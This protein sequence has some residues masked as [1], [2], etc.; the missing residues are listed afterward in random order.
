MILIAFLT[1]GTLAAA[2]ADLDGVWYS[3]ALGQIENL[4]LTPEGEARHAGYD[5]LRDDAAMQCIPS[6]FTR[7]MNTPSPPIEI[8]QHDNYVEINYEY[9]DIR[10]RVPLDPALT[11][12]D[13]PVTVTQHPHMGRSIGRYEGETLV[14]DTAGQAAGVLD[15]VADPGLP[16]SEQMRTQERFTADGDLMEVVVTHQD[17]VNYTTPLVVRFSYHRLDSEILGWGCTVEE[18]GYERFAPGPR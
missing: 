11:L 15:T 9:M 14:V 18:A 6:T 16:Q 17:P 7:V 3:G 2:Q 1:S 10:R 8:R 12:D 4:N 5:H 13:A